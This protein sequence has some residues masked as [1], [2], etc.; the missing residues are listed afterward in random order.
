MKQ[1]I[2]FTLPAPYPLQSAKKFMP[3][4]LYTKMKKAMRGTII[5]ALGGPQN[6]PSK[7][8]SYA[9][10]RIERWSVEKPS[11]EALEGGGAPSLIESL[12][13]FQRGVQGVYRTPYGLG[14][15]K[16][17]SPAHITVEYRAI[18]CHFSEQKTV[19][20]IKDTGEMEP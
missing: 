10:I 3:A 8:F 6:I 16:D 13:A 5:A 18:P 4:T 7:P 15:I 1:T 19:V 17:A 20:T 12:T 2:H 9:H 14:I 11:Q